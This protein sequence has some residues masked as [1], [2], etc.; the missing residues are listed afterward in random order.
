VRW[1][2]SAV[3]PGIQGVIYNDGGGRGNE[4]WADDS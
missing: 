4:I 1:T 2:V 3:G